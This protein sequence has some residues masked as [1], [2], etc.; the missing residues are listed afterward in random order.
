MKLDPN[1]PK[2]LKSGK[3]MNICAKEWWG[4]LIPWAKLQWHL[5]WFW[6]V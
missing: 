6:L 3:M 5:E 1:L 2:L 4:P